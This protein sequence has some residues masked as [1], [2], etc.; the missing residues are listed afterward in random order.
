MS[1][2]SDFLYRDSGLRADSLCRQL[3]QEAPGH[4][5]E[6]GF[7][8]FLISWALREGDEWWAPLDRW[9][10]G[11]P[12]DIWLLHYLT[13]DPLSQAAKW[14]QPTSPGQLDAYASTLERWTDYY[15][16]EGVDQIGFG[17][18]I[19]RRRSGTTNWLRK[20]S[21]K[22]G[23][24]EQRGRVR[25]RGCGDSLRRGPGHGETSVP[26]RL[27]CAPELMMASTGTLL[28]NHPAGCSATT[29]RLF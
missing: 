1:P 20:D 28:P 25:R 26:A 5:E 11:L 21:F 24:G 14:N 19:M 6:G 7:A 2:D 12:C 23:H 13:N 15:R 18:V 3:I 10:E 22:G 16:R 8:H 17:A 29:T 9:I 27:S 4:L